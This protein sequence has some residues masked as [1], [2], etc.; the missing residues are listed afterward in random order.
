MNNANIRFDII[1][2]G[3]FPEDSALIK[4]GVQASTYGL[5]RAL[6]TQP[7]IA[8][9]KVIALPLKAGSQI[10]TRNVDGIDTTFLNAPYRFLVSSIMHLPR[11][12][13]IIHSYANPV[14]HV[15]GTGLFQ[16]ALCLAARL[17]KIPL[18]WTLHGITE[19]EIAMQLHEKLTIGNIGRYLLYRFLERS[20]LR[21]VPNIIVDTPYVLEAVPT[22]KQHIQVIPQGIFMDELLPLRDRTREPFLIL[23]LGVMAPRKSHHLLLEAFAKV[24]EQLP[25]AT[26]VIAGALA[27]PGYFQMLQAKAKQLGIDDAV[28]FGTNLPRAQILDMLGRARV[29]ALHSAEESQGI[30]LCEALAAG[31]PI[32]ATRIG[33]I[34]YVVSDGENGI[35]TNYGDIDA[36]AAGIS[37][38][39]AD[40]TLYDR[41]RAQAIAASARFDWNNIATDVI[42]VYERAA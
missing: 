38:L 5:S 10:E 4:G 39:L 30:A 6:L 8:S 28:A 21:G 23:S 29:F 37:N 36:F 26:L 7:R 24:R 33:G 12:L 25:Q 35:L 42:K 22:T 40:S 11:T 16:A 17:K 14:V 34:P 1:T 27:I 31:M 19:K 41:M 32:V 3:Q 20:M 9:V 2:V 18:V 13:R 15:H